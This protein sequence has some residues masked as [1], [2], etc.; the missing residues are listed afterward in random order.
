ML[1]DDEDVV[2]Q[3]R[4]IVIPLMEEAADVEFEGGVVPALAV[5]PRNNAERRDLG[6]QIRDELRAASIPRNRAN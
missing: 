3:L 6:R 2:A 4:A 5:A 1:E